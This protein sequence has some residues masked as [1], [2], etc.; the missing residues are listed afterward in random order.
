MA[1]PDCRTSESRGANIGLSKFY[2]QLFRAVSLSITS[3]TLGDKGC[4]QLVLFTLRTLTR[5]APEFSHDSG[6]KR[7]SP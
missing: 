6:S 3:N 5:I 1:R 2:G 7:F 4:P